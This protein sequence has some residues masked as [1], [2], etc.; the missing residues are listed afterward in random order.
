MG[1]DMYVVD[2]TGD[3]VEEASL[4]NVDWND[5]EAAALAVKKQDE[6]HCYLRRNIWG[7]GRFRERLLD[8]DLLYRARG[9]D[10]GWPNLP[11][12]EY[13]AAG[14]LIHPFDDPEHWKRTDGDYEPVSEAAKAYQ[15]QITAYLKDTRDERP[16][17]PVH[18]FSSNDGWWITAAECQSFIQ[19][20]ERAGCPDLMPVE[21]RAEDP[22]AEDDIIPFMRQAASHGGFRVY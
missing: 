22:D 15:D 4:G 19:L 18:K 3:T 7:M 1:Y 6:S 14:Q 9:A 5:R 12:R 17:I 13:D 2:E 20:W 8:L 11:G 10:P 16:G 21:W